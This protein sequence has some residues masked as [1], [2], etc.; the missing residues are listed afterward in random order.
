M[1]AIKK[2]Y[3]KIAITAGLALSI[4]SASCLYAEEESQ[5][6]Q[7]EY[8]YRG[9]D[10][11]IP[12]ETLSVEVQESVLIGKDSFA[13][14]EEEYEYSFIAPLTGKY[15][16]SVDDV[17]ENSSV[18]VNLY[19]SLGNGAGSGNATISLVGDET[20]TIKVQSNR[21]VTDFTLNMYCQPETIS[22]PEDITSVE[23]SIYFPG[24]V[25]EYLFVA[26]RSGEYYFTKRNITPNVSVGIN[27]IE[28][29]YG[30]GIFSDLGEGLLVNG[31]YTLTEGQEYKITVYQKGG[32]YGKYALDIVQAKPQPEVCGFGYIK[33]RIDYTDQHNW[34]YFTAPVTGAYRFTAPDSGFYFSISDLNSN[35]INGYWTK[36][37]LDVDLI[38]GETYILVFQYANSGGA[39]GPYTIELEYPAEAESVLSVP[40][41]NTGEE[42][43]EQAASDAVSDDSGSIEELKKENKQLKEENEALK[44]ELEKL[45]MKYDLLTEVLSDSGLEIGD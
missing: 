15:Y 9:E 3:F 17:N 23:D 41:G 6:F 35:G 20:Y 24:Q 32:T 10:H 12:G 37:S 44:D 29:T 38:E 18:S 2:N 34:Y 22:L 42:E 11:I 30:N 28:T 19:D 16:L 40:D 1:L 27:M 13:S 39:K 36:T 4:L 21:G 7:P 26:P 25:N 33:D 14:G 5:Y 31:L 8:E 43:D 45:Q